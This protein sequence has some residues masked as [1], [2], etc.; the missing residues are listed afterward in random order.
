MQ[1]EHC[2]RDPKYID[3]IYSWSTD[4]F[5]LYVTDYTGGRIHLSCMLL[6]TLEYD[7]IC[8]VCSWLHWSTDTFV[9]YV[10]D[11]TGVRIHLFCMGWNIFCKINY[12]TFCIRTTNWPNTLIR[13]SKSIVDPG[14]IIVHRIWKEI[15]TWTYRY[16]DKQ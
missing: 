11:Y 13:F 7:Y 14:M 3:V 8:H 10:T 15:H 2:D 9:L 1:P 16:R 12:N 4:T 6:T 5:V